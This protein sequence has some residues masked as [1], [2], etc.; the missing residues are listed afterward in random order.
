VVGIRAGALGDW[1]AA[2]CARLD[3]RLNAY[4]NGQ[5]R[6]IIYEFLEQPVP[7]VLQGAGRA[8]RTRHPIVSFLEADERLVSPGLPAAEMAARFERGDVCLA[9]FAPG[10]DGAEGL[11]GHLW[12]TEHAYLEKEANCIFVLSPAARVWWDYH[13]FVSPRYRGGRLFL[14]LWEAA[15]SLLSERGVVSTI[16]QVSWTNQISRQ[17]HRRLGSRP[18]G[19]AVILRVFR[20]SAVFSPSLPLLRFSYKRPV[21]VPLHSRLLGTKA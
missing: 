13:L 17:S 6:L 1:L 3:G 15:Q 16:S 18:I 8:D 14:R 21:R 9:A 19:W 2:C 20:S 12:L 11:A 5:M 10:E 4:T 7:A